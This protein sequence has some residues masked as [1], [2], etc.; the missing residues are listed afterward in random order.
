MA[1]AHPKV[2]QIRQAI[3]D[4]TELALASDAYAAWPEAQSI[5]PGDMVLVN[6]S[7]LFRG[8]RATT[9][10]DK[11][12]AVIADGKGLLELEPHIVTA[13]RI[14]SQFKR[15]HA[16][17]MT[18]YQLQ[19][20][21][22]MIAHEV[23]AIGSIVMALVGRIG[24][25]EAAEA[26]LDGPGSVRTL[27]FVPH[28]KHHVE[29]L[30]DAISLNS[31]KNLDAS[32]SAVQ[33][34]IVGAGLD[35]ARVEEGFET[36]FHTLQEAAARSVDPGNITDAGP[37][38]LREV[39]R[40]MNDHVKAFADTLARYRARPQDGDTYNELLRIS[41]NFADG[42]VA[43]LNLMVGICDLKPII[44]WLTVFEQ[45]ELA[46]LFGQLPFALVGKGKPSLERYR[47]VIADGRNQ[48]FHDLF[49]FDHPFRVRLPGDALR[50]PEL[51]LFREY[52]RRNDPILNFEDRTLIELFEA[53]TRTPERPVP[54]GFW[55]KNQQVMGAVAEVVEAL[56]K[57]LVLVA[58]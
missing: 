17:Q 48:A 42:A 41:Y 13:G 3:L 56:R 43:F 7:F 55:D 16:T 38:I 47:S 18:K 34:T 46:H 51:R 30:S 31:V 49:G 29:L 25:A 6:N 50:S 2:Q 33:A 11:Y 54:L 22:T 1:G 57:A 19:D 26:G 4:Q 21:D 14:I 12:L 58:L 10:S 35:A 39:S 5:G 44:F 40:R 9:K 28:Q 15:I 53:L 37:S 45:I 24:D 23:A 27:R 32:W 8:A 52:N 20:L 36:A